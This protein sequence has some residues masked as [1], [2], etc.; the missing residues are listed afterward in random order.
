MIARPS[1]VASASL[2]LLVPPLPPAPIGQMESMFYFIRLFFQPLEQLPADL[3]RITPGVQ[4]F[5]QLFSGISIWD[6]M[7]AIKKAGS[8][9]QKLPGIF[10]RSGE[11]SPF[12]CC[13]FLQGS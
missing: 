1:H 13:C 7:A 2:I 6:K 12:T 4:P 8:V 11:F 3:Q 10:C 9:L 5:N